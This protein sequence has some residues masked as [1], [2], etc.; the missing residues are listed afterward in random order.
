MAIRMCVI[1]TVAFLFTRWRP[2]RRLVVSCA[3]GR[4]K[5]ALTVIFGA[6]G[7][8]GTYSGVPVLGAIAN[9]RVVAAAV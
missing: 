5:V 8:M 1:A 4:E 3:D 2:F 6:L 7:I 9:H